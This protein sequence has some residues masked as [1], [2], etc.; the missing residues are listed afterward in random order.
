ME[1]AAPPSCP[2]CNKVFS[3]ANFA[4]LESHVDMCLKKQQRSR[5][6]RSEGSRVASYREETDLLEE[7]EVD[8]VADGY[9]SSFS[10]DSEGSDGWSELGIEAAEAA[11]PKQNKR[12]RPPALKS[13]SNPRKKLIVQ[14]KKLEES[15]RPLSVS[16]PFVEIVDDLDRRC[17]ASRLESLREMESRNTDEENEEYKSVDEK[18]TGGSF[19]LDSLATNFGAMVND[20]I[21]NQLYPHQKQGCEWLWNLYKEGCGGILA[22]EMGLG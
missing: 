6:T 8:E 14:A 7:G 22:D 15:N 21:W 19:L 3:S 13:S 10:L 5:R 2:I 11:D 4:M 12:S 9:S 17:Y 16:A 20:Q 18:E 1:Q